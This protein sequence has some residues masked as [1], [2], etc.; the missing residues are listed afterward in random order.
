MLYSSLPLP[1]SYTA[2]ASFDGTDTT[3]TTYSYPCPEVVPNSAIYFY[4]FN[5]PAAPKNLTWTTRFTIAAADGSTTP[6]ANATQ[7]NGDKIPWGIGALVDPSKATPIPSYLN[8]STASN[9]ST[10]ATTTTT[11]ATSSA[12]SST[13]TSSSSSSALMTTTSDSQTS[14]QAQTV[15][16][17]STVDP[18]TST[19]SSSS[20][21]STGQGNNALGGSA[22]ASFGAAALAMCATAA[23][24]ALMS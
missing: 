20:G 18:S 22:R 15:T 14:A 10:T 21:S 5:T 9:S 7:P 4:Q 6:P 1:F 2:V 24:F 12:S 19:D 11:S 16:Q 23:A 3:K 17:T 8:A 13:S